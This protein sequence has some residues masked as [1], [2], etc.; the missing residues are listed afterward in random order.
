MDLI[1]TDTKKG[2][3]LTLNVASARFALDQ[4]SLVSVADLDGTISYV[5][6]KFCQISGYSESEL[7]G[8]K[9]NILNS[10]AQPKS[11]WQQMHETVLA[12]DVWHDEVRNRAKNGQ[13]YWVDT[14]VVPNYDSDDKII[15]FTSIR[16]DITKQKQTIEQLDVAIEQAESAKFALDQHSLVSITDLEGNILYVNQQFEK[17]SGY[18]KEEL[19]G[20]KHSILNSGNQPKS[21]WQKMHGKVLSGKVWQDEVRNRAKDGSYY[22]VDTTIVPNFNNKNEVIGFT[23]IRTDIT[24]QKE[25]LLDI[26]NAKQQAEAAI[27]ALDQHSLVSITDLQG[28]ITYVNKTFCEISGYQ[29]HE[30]LGKKH[31]ILNSGNEP[32]SFWQKMHGT[33]LSG[34]VWRDEVRNRAKNGSYYWVDTTIVPNFNFKKEIIGFTSIRTDITEQ[35]ENIQ[36]LEVAKKAAEGANQAKEEFL[37]NMSH[38]IRTPMN[39]VYASLQLLEKNEMPYEQ[40]ELVNQSLFSCECLLTIINDILDFSKI[41]AGHLELEN[42]S[43]DIRNI[44]ES[45]ASDIMPTINKEKVMLNVAISN[46]LA[47]H[48]LGDPVRI[49]QILLNL[50]SNAVKFTKKG[51]ITISV[52]PL[53]DNDRHGI[54]MH[55]SDTG[56]GMSKDAVA[57]LFN[58]FSQADSSTTR[59]YGGTGLGMSITHSLVQMMKGNISVESQESIG[60]TF[61]INLPLE[62]SNSAES[63]K[64]SNDKAVCPNLTGK[65]VLV[66]DDTPINRVI[67]KKALTFTKANILEAE[68]GE[69]AYDMALKFKPDM[70]FMDIQM[71]I[72]DGVSSLRL[73]RKAQFSSPIVAFTANV[74]KH[75]VERYL[76]EGFSRCISKPLDIDDFY[77]VLTELML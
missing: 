30:L 2:K 41:E 38:E 1:K 40:R 53:N 62:P 46:D 16:T 9:H 45:V 49:K 8:K 71:P 22:W 44:I 75:D 11:Y 63:S 58:R 29:E 55:V 56:I 28:N 39:G 68:N 66:V 52:E 57:K 67:M 7:L 76:Q 54:L 34:E 25:N 12:G 60:T 15:G 31:N 48:W 64:T 27:F 70:V 50:V 23:S 17:I 14:T 10:N 5:N 37:A 13:Y 43:F 3:A 69:Q 18:T 35:K 6:D 51:S 65:T 4:H 21:Y 24:Q 32:K 47:T 33:V 72:M 61:N 77:R 42:I 73:L 36:Q 19:I 59:K 20:R 26:A 74:F